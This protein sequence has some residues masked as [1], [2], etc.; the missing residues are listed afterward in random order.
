MVSYRCADLQVSGATFGAKTAHAPLHL[1]YSY[2]DR[3]IWL[4]ESG[5]TAH[6][7]VTATATIYS[8]SGEVVWEKSMGSWGAWTAFGGT[9]EVRPCAPSFDTRCSSDLQ[10]VAG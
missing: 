4:V 7:N 8:L 10:R 5:Y 3:S 6:D 1:Q 2:D 9:W